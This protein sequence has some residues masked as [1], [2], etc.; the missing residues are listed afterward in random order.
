M[1]LTLPLM[2]GVASSAAVAGRLS[3][4]DHASLVGPYSVDAALD[5]AMRNFTYTRAQQ[6]LPARA[7]LLAVFDAL[8]LGVDCNMTQP[9][10]ATAPPPPFYAAPPPLEG[11]LRTLPLPPPGSRVWFVDAAGGADAT[12]CGAVASPCATVAFALEQSRAGGGGGALV[13]RGGAPH[14]LR[15]PLVLGT[16]DSGLSIAA[17][18]GEAPLVSGGAHLPPLVWTRVG[19]SPDP[20]ANATLWSAPLPADVAVPF[21]SLYGPDARRRQLA[22]WPNGNP[23][24]ADGQMPNGYTKAAA[25]LPPLPPTTALLQQNPQLGTLPRTVCPSDACTSQGP[26]GAGPPWAIFCCFFW[27][28]NGTAE[29]FT[30]GSFWGVHPGPPGGGTVYTP[31]GMTAGPDLLP[32]LQRWATPADAVVHAFHREYWGNWM[33]PVASVVNATSGNV[34]FAGGGFQEARGAGAGDYYFVEGPREELDAA[35]EFFVD[36][37]SRTLLY[38]ANGTDTPPAAGWVAGQ[39]DNLFTLEGTPAAPVADVAIAGLTLAFTAPTFLKH[40]TAPSGGDWS[41]Q[42]GGAL[43]LTGTRNC[44]VEGALFVNLGGTGVMLSGW[45]RGA[46]MQDCEFLRVGENAVVSAGLGG[47]QHDNSA[48]HASVGEGLVLARNLAH[49]LGVIVKQAGFYYHAMTANATVVENVLFNGPRA[50]INI[51]DG[52]G[53]GHDVSRNVAFNLVRETS[54]HGPFNSWDRNTYKW[55]DGPGGTDPLLSRLDQNLFVANYHTVVPIDH[56]DGSN[57]YLDTRNVLLWGGTKNLMGYNKRSVN[58]TMVYVDY[59]PSLV[60]PAELQQRMGWSV[61]MEGSGGGGSSS[62]RDNTTTHPLLSSSSSSPSSS[63]W[64]SSPWPSSP[65]TKPPLCAAYLT[66]FPASTGQADSWVNNTCIATSEASFFRFYACNSSD[67]HDG[68]IPVPMAGNRYFSTSAAYV[69]HCGEEAWN[70]TQAQAHGVDLDSTLHALPTTD[71][72]VGL[73]SGLLA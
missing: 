61:G 67:P 30:T 32:R 69:L 16:A 46:S 15:A 57:G 62:R 3:D 59:L 2:L 21:Q 26:S 12:G 1:R 70:L 43:R 68:S 49:E 23:E 39:L 27:G 73:M 19:P 5:C 41:F 50:G 4:A 25:W 60:A 66:W 6:V 36:A 40:F 10:A 47:I 29:N 34:A 65:Q 35:G 44:S 52:F 24:T 31:G 42:D 33:F 64:W 20:A 48:P 9:A 54:D 28:V 55:R 11:V 37:G 18:P 17:Y 13:L 8:R 71:E 58:N 22:R 38:C 63:S 53:G 51:N 45:N 72:L 14:V 7:P 56:D